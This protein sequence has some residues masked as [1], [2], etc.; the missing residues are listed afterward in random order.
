MSWEQFKDFS[1]SLADKKINFIIEPYL[2]F[3]DKPGEQLTMFLKDPF[4][5]AIEFKAFKNDKDLFK[6]L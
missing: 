3:K 5:N 6:A 4:G 2:R 1:Q